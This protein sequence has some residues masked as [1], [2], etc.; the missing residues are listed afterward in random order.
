MSAAVPAKPRLTHIWADTIAPQLCDHPDCRQQIYF[1]QNVR[2]GTP[3]P[4]NTRPEPVMITRELGTNREQWTID[5]NKTVNH[6]AT[7]VGRNNFGRRAR[8]RR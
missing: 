2:T 8:G 5:L 7:C 4:Y 6:F 1:A 3:A